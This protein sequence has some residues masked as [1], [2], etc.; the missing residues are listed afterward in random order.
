[1]SLDVSRLLA[2]V[3]DEQPSGPDLEYDADFLAMAAAAESKPEQQM[4]DSVIPAEEPE[5]REVRQKALDLLERT[6][7]VRVAV[8]LCRS[9]LHVDGF[10]GFAEGLAVL[11][12]LLRDFWPTLHPELDA[13]DNDDPTM[14]VNALAALSD[15]AGLVRS[16][17][18]APL[19]RARMAGSYSLRDIELANAGSGGERD[20][21]RPTPEIVNAAFLEAPLEEVEATA[22]AITEA[23]DSLREIDDALSGQLGPQSPDL[24]PLATVL[25]Q[26][27]RELGERL[28]ARGSSAAPDGEGSAD[29]GAGDDAGA[30]VAASGGGA[31]AP[32][33]V[34]SRQDV[35]RWID[36]ICD[37]YRQKE[38][39]SPVP[40]L[41]QRARKLVDMTF[42][43]VVKDLVP[44][45][46]NQAEMF[47]GPEE[48]E[49]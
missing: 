1:M 46:L 32:A 42:L 19:V 5:W 44:E 27:V 48:D 29:A 8:L 36:R 25:A 10:A 31:S 28:A 37:Y 2:P 40:V 3:S 47:R 11:R 9:L 20:E 33:T 23:R 39:S 21:D 18:D 43:D 4:G 35:V 17:R 24:Q 16:L 15:G 41:L 7:D 45:G 34:Q 14:R 13:S 12:G 38:P 30:A 22:A 26:Q 6:K 49:S